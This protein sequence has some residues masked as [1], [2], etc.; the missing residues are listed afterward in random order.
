MTG[1]LLIILILL[2]ILDLIL[3]RKKSQ[4][5]KKKDVNSSQPEDYSEAY[6]ARYLLTQ[7][8][9]HEYKKLKEYADQKN[10]QICPKVRLLDLV[11]P[12][13]GDR[14]MSRLGKIQSK[15]VDFVITDQNL[16]VKAI[17]ELDDGSHDTESRKERDLFVDQVL[18]SVGYRVIHTRSICEDTLTKL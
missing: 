5:C 6:Q 4:P 10:L 11:E 1:I 14:Y 8:E 7:N 18:T 15:H 3:K 16:R 12:R 17:L 9:W 13:S 2:V